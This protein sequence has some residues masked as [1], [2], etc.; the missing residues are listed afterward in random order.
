LSAKIKLEA[1]SKEEIIKK[2]LELDKKLDDMKKKYESDI[3]RLNKELK[4][5]KNAHTPSSKLSF[6]KPKALGL[7]VGRK[8]GK[9]S[10]HK[11]KT[12]A[13]EKHNKVRIVSAEKNPITGNTNIK[14]TGITY[15][16]IITDFQIKKIVTEFICKEYIDLDTGET[17]VAK[18]PDMPD[19]GIFGNNVQAFTN[20][21][22]FKCRVPFDKISSTFTGV[23][24]IPMTAPTAMA[25]CNR[26][27]NKLSYK[28]EELKAA[29]KIEKAVNADETGANKNGIPSW[30]WGFFSNAVALFVFNT[31]RGG[32]IVERILGKEF[33]GKLGCDGWST[34]AVFSKEYGILLQR[35]WAHLLREIKYAYKKNKEL[36]EAYIWIN[37][38]FKG[39]KKARKLKSKHLRKQ[40][41]D[42]LVKELEMWTQT[43][44]AYKGMREIITKVKNGG[45]FWFT[46]VLYPEIEPTNNSAERGLRAWRV[47]EKIIGCLRT[48][49]GQ[50]T[51]EIML[52]L[53]QT[54]DLRKVNPYEQLKVLL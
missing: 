8:L 48:E 28:Y 54:W 26:T 11:G 14:E 17:F 38:I 50:K 42:K 1:L 6:D 36:E 3:E 27:A 9:K 40:R 18:H 30:L 49:Q 32:D 25:I 10:R 4:K 20:W 34:Y 23:F 22:R 51:T 53:F 2:Y 44:R 43:F 45:E 33:K 39:V 16:K 5:Y 7:K 15:S 12:N 21:L 29:I 19:K 52:S 37:D 13:K 46:C 31:K 47:L 24:G 41:Y 35:C